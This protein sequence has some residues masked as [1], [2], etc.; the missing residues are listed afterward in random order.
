MRGLEEQNHYEVLEVS[1]SAEP[2]EIERAFRMLQAT[3][4][5]DSL[6]LYSLF[7]EA[8]A[9]AIQKRIEVAY[10]VLSDVS[11]RRAYDE[12][13]DGW[14]VEE[15]DQ[16]SQQAVPGA[17][18]APVHV[19]EGDDR[20]SV[21]AGES[22]ATQAAPS[23]GAEIAGFQ[24]LEG[25]AE[26]GEDFDGSWLR[27]ARLRRGIEIDQISNVTKVS[28]A[29][30]RSLEGEVY[31]ELPPPVYVRGFVIAY[32]RAI[33]LEGTKVATSYIERMEESKRGRRKG[34]LRRR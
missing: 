24:D 16:L 14:G 29:L 25:D 31:D 15:D 13:V 21:A 9:I 1:Q 28:P 11:A 6:A 10:Q 3:Y 34:R 19:T 27:R 5:S 4:E 26:E 17:G 8:D 33:G 18:D 22:S 12:E 2:L 20:P 32:A 30:L 23:T 7:D